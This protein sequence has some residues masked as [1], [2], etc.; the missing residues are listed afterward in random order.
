[1]NKSKVVEIDVNGIPVG[2]NME[3]GFSSDKPL[4]SLLRAGDNCLVDDGGI[5]RKGVVQN[6]IRLSKGK[7]LFSV[8]LIN[9]ILKEWDLFE[10]EKVTPVDPVQCMLRLTAYEMIL[11]KYEPKGQSTNVSLWGT[12]R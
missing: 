4:Y 5:T 9:N 2:L 6:I 8:K 10:G 3:S 1:M 12:E 11:R 7:T